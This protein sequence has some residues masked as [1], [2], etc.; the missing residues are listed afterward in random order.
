MPL[1]ARAG[2]LGGVHL[3]GDDALSP[4]FTSLAIGIHPFRVDYS[5]DTSYVPGEYFSTV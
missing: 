1:G 4:V 2:S 5:G 3:L